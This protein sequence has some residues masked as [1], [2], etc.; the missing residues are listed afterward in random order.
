MVVALHHE[1]TGIEWRG[2]NRTGEHVKGVN[3]CNY[4]PLHIE[5]TMP[6]ERKE[7]ELTNGIFRNQDNK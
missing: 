3:R 1:L 4:S 6:G 7:A 5:L 2:F